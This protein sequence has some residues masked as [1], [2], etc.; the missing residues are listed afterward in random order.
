MSGPAPGRRFPAAPFVVG[1]AIVVAAVLRLAWVSWDPASRLSWSNGIF[2]DPP[3]MVYAARNAALFG[4][5]IVD[6]NRD[7][8][9]FP[10]ANLLTRLAYLL[11]GPSRVATIVISALAG[12]ATVAA[13]AWGLRRSLGARAAAI[14]AA[15][16]AT[17]FFL[18]LYARI[19]IAENLV[20]AMMTAAAALAIGNSRRELA[21]A[22][23][24]AVGATL[25]GKYHAVGL[26][27]GLVLFVAL[28]PDPR[29]SLAALF[30]GGTVVFL[31]W[32]FLLF[33]PHRADILPHVAR[34]ST[35]M[36][37]SLPLADSLTEGIGEF[38]NAVRR[39]WVFYRM[40]F[41]GA[42]GG[43]F[44]FW[45]VG[46]RD[47]RRARL[48]DGSAIWAFLFFSSW[49]Y[50]AVLPYKAPRYYVPVA[51]LL[52]AA[53]AAAIELLLRSPGIRFRPPSRWDE[54]L[55]L[56]LWLYCFVFT[57]LDAA[58]HYASI[59]LE[60]L[61]TP[62]PRISD[63]TYEA[64]VGV[65]SRID[66]FEQGLVWAGIL[67]IVGYVA[68]LWNPE[69]LSRLGRREAG[70]SSRGL[71]RLAIVLAAGSVT[72]GLTQWSWWAGH[73]THFL[74]DAK[75]S[76]PLMVGEDA[77]LLGPF[78]PLLTQDSKLRGY[79]YFG[80][81]GERGILEK[82]GVTHVIL[83]GSGDRE[84]IEKRFPGLLDSTVTVD[85]AP[86]RTLFAGTM[87]LRRLPE[88]W[89]GVPIH[90]YEPTA[91]ERA[92]SAL[93]EDPQAA[94]ELFSR[95]RERAGDFPELVSLEAACWFRLDD[96]D[97]AEKGIREAIAMR[98]GDPSNYRSLCLV[99]LKRGDRAAALVELRHALRLD[100][101][102]EE[103]RDMLEELT[104]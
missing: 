35:G 26:L 36:H 88:T 70:I 37:G 61:S 96:Y 78:A 1:L 103:L 10:L 80:P 85:V 63:A 5:W 40:P 86:V 33:L 21:A 69:L 16:A 23:A 31:G 100:P 30:G 41:A 64:V 99:H 77:V 65:F 49:F 47:A 44:A 91:F 95:H 101:T 97:R 56:A 14:G 73:R 7:L 94:L 52:V 6:Y 55:P 79:P 20:A 87:E 57:G 90:H 83:S 38:F 72:F 2:T 82:Y 39:C 62:P 104:R 93:E 89:R 58:K 27:P 71:R 74:E 43:L 3:V 98:P 92:V 13:V 51:P 102:D 18:T 9:V 76:L 29:R 84:L 4:E 75:S 25:F 48:A 22:V 17:S 53:A 8:W 32:F 59:T 67:S 12:T 24:L 19:P 50:Y 34:Q 42:A 46:N 66:T 11:T 60:Y 15:M 45:V 68:I 81:P 28:R 54:H